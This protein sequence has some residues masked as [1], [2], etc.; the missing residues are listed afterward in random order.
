MS[1]SLLLP[2]PEVAAALGLGRT[3]VY[4]LIA[5]GQL[6]AVHIGRSCRVPADSVETFVE[7]LRAG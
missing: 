3:K 4:E 5:T 1:R 7:R 2:I 6:E